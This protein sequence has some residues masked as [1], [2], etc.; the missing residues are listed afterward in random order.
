MPLIMDGT[1]ADDT[2]CPGE[3][4]ELLH[5]LGSWPYLHIERRTDCAILRTRDLV[6]GTLNLAM[7]ALSVNVPPDAVGPMML[8]SHPLVRRTTDGA[9]VHVTD[10]ESRTVAETL[11][12]WRVDLERFAPQRRTASP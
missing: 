1:H 11:L 12:R 3:V 2:Q 7:H 9:S 8:E 5:H 4:D 6:V 10:S